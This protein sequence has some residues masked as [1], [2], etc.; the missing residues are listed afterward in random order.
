MVSVLFKNTNTKNN[1][2]HGGKSNEKSI[3]LFACIR[4]VRL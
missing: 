2:I 1:E 4:E 3:I